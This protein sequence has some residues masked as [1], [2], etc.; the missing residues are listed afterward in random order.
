MAVAALGVGARC[1]REPRNTG[2]QAADARGVAPR[3]MWVF[4]RAR[5][6][7][8]VRGFCGYDLGSLFC[9]GPAAVSS[10]AGKG[11]QRQGQRAALSFWAS[12]RSVRRER[13]LWSWVF[14]LG[15]ILVGFFF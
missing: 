9:R 1:R 7:P 2:Q 14:V 3:W 15:A 5:Q 4:V 10:A 6:A 13:D 12:V 11:W 8:R